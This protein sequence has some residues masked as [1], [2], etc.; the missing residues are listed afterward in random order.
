M[1]VKCILYIN[2]IIWYSEFYLFI[3]FILGLVIYVMVLS[4]VL[5]RDNVGSFLCKYMK[6][7]LLYN[8]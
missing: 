8:K 6:E 4:S 3:F 7:N 1:G 5:Y 2:E